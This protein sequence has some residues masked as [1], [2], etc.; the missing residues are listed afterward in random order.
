MRLAYDMRG[1]FF[2]RIA[3]A[4]YMGRPRTAKH[5]KAAPP[6]E[7]EDISQEEPEEQPASTSSHGK[8]VTKAEAVRQAIAA[9][10]DAPGDISDFAKSH[11]GLD[12]PKPQ[13]SAYKAQL[14]ARGK[15]AGGE[16]TP[17]ARRGRKPKAAVEGYLAPPPKVVPTGEGDLLEALKSIKH[18]VSTHGVAK[19]HEMVDLLG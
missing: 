7:P 1:D 5:P 18:L 11:F 9:G 8:T 19:V 14:K 13:A 4:P 16:A 3:G 10:M 15:K 17:K 2:S 12:I 6:P